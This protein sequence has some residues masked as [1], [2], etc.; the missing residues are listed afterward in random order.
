MSVDVD[1]SEGMGELTLTML[2]NP[3]RTW[4]LAMSVRTV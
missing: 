2:T 4:S 3:S 1:G